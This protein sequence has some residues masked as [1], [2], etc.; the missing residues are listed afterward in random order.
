[1]PVEMSGMTLSANITNSLKYSEHTMWLVMLRVLISEEY[2]GS[3]GALDHLGKNEQLEG[4]QI[5]N[6]A[7]DNATGTAG[8]MHMAET[9]SKR[10]PK[11]SVVSV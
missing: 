8:V 1:M 6:G 9:F 11:R 2:V 5:F 3:Y 10:T 7:L 4:D